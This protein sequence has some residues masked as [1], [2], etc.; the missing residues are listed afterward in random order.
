[1]GQTPCLP[2]VRRAEAKQSPLRPQEQKGSASVVDEK[3]GMRKRIRLIENIF[4]GVI[5]APACHNE[6]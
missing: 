5:H 6:A 1:M 2:K 3:G 4:K